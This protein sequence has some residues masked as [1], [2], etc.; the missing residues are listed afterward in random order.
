MIKRSPIKC[1]TIGILATGVILAPSAGWTQ[2]RLE[3][4][5]SRLHHAE[6]S[7]SVVATRPRPRPMTGTPDGSR[8]GGGTRPAELSNRCGQTAHPPIAIVPEDGKGATAREVPVVWFYMP[9][10]SQDVDT[11][12]FSVHDRNETTTLYRA[13]IQL[14]NTPG[15]MSIAIP[16]ALEMEEAYQWKLVINCHENASGYRDFALDGWIMRTTPNPTLAWDGVW[17]DALTD[18]ATR[19]RADPQNIAV[20]AAWVGLLEQVGLADLASNTFVNVSLLPN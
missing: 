10:T 8:I 4:E 15:M 5:P 14:S 18:L 19:Y 17:H 13:S 16:I 3:L 1:F 11:V 6:V 7:P 12:E 20:R 9:Y 2:D